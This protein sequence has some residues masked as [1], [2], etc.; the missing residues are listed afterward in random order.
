MS[1]KEKKRD[2][3][4]SKTPLTLAQA[5][6]VLGVHQS[7]LRRAIANG[8]LKA[9]RLHPTGNYRVTMDE[10]ERFIGKDKS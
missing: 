4:L 1:T 5:A 2:F 9:F 3:A 10:I 7:T 8:S 6:K